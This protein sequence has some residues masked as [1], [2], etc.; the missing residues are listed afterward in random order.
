MARVKRSEYD[1]SCYMFNVCDFSGTGVCFLL[2][3]C[4]RQASASVYAFFPFL[5]RPLYVTVL[6][7]FEKMVI[8]C[9]CSRELKDIFYL[10]LPPLICNLHKP[11]DWPSVIASVRVPLFFLALSSD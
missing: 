6:Q 9:T 3:I 11:Q 5:P 1:F 10:R 4:G 7:M 2:S 8:N